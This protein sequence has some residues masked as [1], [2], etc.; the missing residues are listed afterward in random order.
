L[1]IGETEILAAAAAERGAQPIQNLGS[2]GLR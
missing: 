2:T 1:Q